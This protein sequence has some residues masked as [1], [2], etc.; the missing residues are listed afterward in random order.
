MKSIEVVAAI[1]IKDEKILAVQKGKA[2]FDYVS[3]KW[4][5]PGGKVEAGES[6]EQAIQ[7]EILEELH[8]QVNPK[9]LL[10]T[11][12]HTYPD[13]HLVMHCFVCD[14]EYGDIQLTEHIELAWLYRR[15]LQSL[16]WADADIPVVKKLQEYVG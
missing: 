5:L 14:Y 10:I 8:I 2:K 7:R 13:F 4:E 3:Y 15:N 9:E 11:V 16:D 1:I 12:E 6:L